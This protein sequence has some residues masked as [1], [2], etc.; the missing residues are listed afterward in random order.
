[1]PRNISANRKLPH[2][3][4]IP[5]PKNTCMYIL[6]PRW[7]FHLESGLMCIDRNFSFNFT[8]QILLFVL[9]FRFGMY[10]LSIIT[11]YQLF[12]QLLVLLFVNQFSFNNKEFVRAV[13][14]NVKLIV[15]Y[16]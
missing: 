10:H 5:N 16:D 11:I 1:M 12:Y 6:L 14:G 13:C 2:K 9:G 4:G 7:Y 8:T 3:L 15:I